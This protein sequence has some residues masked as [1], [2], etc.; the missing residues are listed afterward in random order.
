[1]RQRHHYIIL[2]ALVLSLLTYSSSVLL[3]NPPV[4]QAS[5]YVIGSD[6]VDGSTIGSVQT[7]HI[8]FNAPISRLTTAH[9]LVVQQGTQNSV[10]IEVGANTGTVSASNPNELIIPLKTA[11]PQGSYLVRWAAVANDDGRTTFGTIGFNVGISSTGLPGTPILGP[12]TSNQ[13]DE[14][15][16]LDADHATN[17]LA[18]LWEWAMIIA[19][20]VWIG[21]LI[22]EQFILS[23]GGRCTELR[24]HTKKRAHSLQWLCLCALL[25]SEIVSF[26]L[27]TTALIGHIHPNTPYLSTLQSLLINTNYGHFWLLRCA[28][29]LTAMA[30]FYW[31]TR[32][33]QQ[34]AEPEPL[35]RLARSSSLR[36][37]TTQGEE[38]LVKSTAPATRTGSIPTRTGTVGIVPNTDPVSKE[39]R[40]SLAWLALSGLI[41]LTLILSRAPAQTFQPHLSAI[42]LDWLNLAALGTWFGSFAYL[43]YLILPLFSHKE[44]EYHIETLTTI[45]RRLIPFILAAIGIEIVSTLFLSEAAISDPQQLLGD[46]Y[47]RTLLIQIAIFITMLS[48]SLYTL[49]WLQSRMKHQ[50]LLLPLVHA[51]L[52][53]RRLRQSELHHTKKTLGTIS[54]SIT[55]LGIGILLCTALMAFFT[56][57]IHFPAITYN[58]QSTGSDGTANAQTKQ[59]GDLS[60]SLQLL[61]RHSNQT[62]T[63][64]LVI[65]DSTGKPVTDA[66]IHLSTNMQAMDMGT[67]QALITGG[68]PVYITTF[69]KNA[70]FNMAGLWVINLNIQRPNQN[71]LQ[72]TFQVMIL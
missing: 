5:A 39:R 20:T 34:L 45:L 44:L 67:G 41:L 40:Y 14:I 21:T 35:P 30:L 1:M 2:T 71:P 46:P 48:L 29:I 38:E 7:I 63:I 66:Q 31:T 68:N 32:H 24:V 59:I 70:T 65:N 25:F 11:A 49:L 42:L 15:R 57:P 43:G 36:S 55:W 54:T 16:A 23:D 58:N 50:I 52:P 60:V 51:D 56:P 17:I 19:L 28:L 47:G 6:P 9:V 12:T 37:T 18:V 72:G 13:L 27:R 53:V 26:V 62:N 10:M 3:L 61:P 8:Y 4:A 22:M 64:L 33:R 69:D